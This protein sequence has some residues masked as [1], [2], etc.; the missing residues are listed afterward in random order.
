MTYWSLDRQMDKNLDLSDRKTYELLKADVDKG[1]WDEWDAMHAGFP[2]GSFSR[3]RHNP[4]PG[5]PGPVRD[6]KN[7]YGLEANS[8]KQQPYR[9]AK[10]KNCLL[11]RYLT[12]PDSWRIVKFS[13]CLFSKTFFVLKTNHKLSISQIPSFKSNLASGHKRGSFEEISLKLPRLLVEVSRKFP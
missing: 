3:A 4:Q 13:N 11:V 5:Q 1:E 2:C 7:I 9:P 10:S 12:S 8:A 6:G